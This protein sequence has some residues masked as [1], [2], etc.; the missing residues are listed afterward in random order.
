MVYRHHD[1]V[2]LVITPATAMTVRSERV[3]VDAS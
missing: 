2:A 3:G 1:A